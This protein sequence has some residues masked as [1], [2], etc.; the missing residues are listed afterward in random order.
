MEQKQGTSVA[1][2]RPISQIQYL[3]ING[4][5]HKGNTWKLVEYAVSYVRGLDKNAE[6]KE[7]QLMDLDLP[8]CTGCS[9]CFRKGGEFCPHYE[10]VGII[11]NALEWADGLI[12]I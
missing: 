2:K 9:N 4:S 6:F 12:Y 8:F 10:K 7:V 1:T 3:V 11:Y 5:P